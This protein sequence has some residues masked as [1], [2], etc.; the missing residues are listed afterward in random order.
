MN[1]SASLAVRTLDPSSIQ[2]QTIHFEYIEKL[3]VVVATPVWELKTEE[4]VRTW[5]RQYETFYEAHFDEPVDTIFDLSYFHVGPGIGP[6][7]GE[8]RAK[9]AKQFTRKTYR[10]HTDDERV[11]TY[12]YT[13]AV[14]YNSEANEFPSFDAAVNA[15]LADRTKAG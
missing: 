6:K 14:K 7:F 9:V 13:S 3:N 15:L 12:M 10:C 8:Y 5:F 11:K 4:D 1:D 2:P